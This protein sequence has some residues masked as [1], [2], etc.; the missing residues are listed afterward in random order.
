MPWCFQTILY[1]LEPGFSQHPH[2]LRTTLKGSQ[3][4]GVDSVK[5]KF[6]EFQ[7]L[8]GSQTFFSN[9]QDK[10]VPGK[11]TTWPSVYR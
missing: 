9:V 10:D 4:V 6:M 5:G 7:K 2:V 3:R 11:F 1:I 8:P